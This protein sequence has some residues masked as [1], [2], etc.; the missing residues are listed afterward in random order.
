MKL[1]FLLFFLAY[2]HTTFSETNHNKLDSIHKDTAIFN[3]KLTLC[4]NLEDVSCVKYQLKQMHDV[5]QY[6]RTNIIQSSELDLWPLITRQ[7]AINTTILK[8][9]LAK[10]FWPKISVFGQ[11]CDSYAWLIA[12]HADHDILF[13]HQVL[14]VLNQMTKT[15]ETKPSH[16]AYMYDRIAV[17]YSAFGIKQRY[18]TQARKDNNNQFIILNFEGT[19]DEVNKQRLALGLPTLN[20]Y[21]QDLNHFYSKTS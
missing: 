15:N 16:Y 13:Q 11:K 1:F 17:K 9:I 19:E 20:E 12:Q 8:K 7:D 3:A 21:R 4:S 18:G 6:L 2:S 5:D 14:F 10:H